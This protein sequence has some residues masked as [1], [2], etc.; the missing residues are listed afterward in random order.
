MESIGPG[1]RMYE[2]RNGLLRVKDGYAGQVW[3]KLTDGQPVRQVQLKGDHIGLLFE[4]GLFRV[5]KGVGGPWFLLGQAGEGVTEFGMESMGDDVRIYEIRQGNLRVKDG[6]LGT[7]TTLSDNVT[8]GAVRQVQL[9]GEVIGVLHENGLFR[10]K[11]G[12]ISSGW[13]EL[14]AVGSGVTE[15]GMGSLGPAV[16]IYEIRQ[17]ALRVKNGIHGL[18]AMLPDR[19]AVRQVQLEDPSIGL[20]LDDGLFRVAPMLPAEVFE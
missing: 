18:W 17:G 16:R 4:N 9:Q 15:F 1:I 12:G 8:N 11:A 2:F 6:V 14:G 10:V 3:T 20:L 13:T 5:K 19:G 7:W